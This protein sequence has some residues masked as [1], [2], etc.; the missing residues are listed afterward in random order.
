MLEIK[1]DTSRIDIKG[2]EKK[3]V[4]KARRRLNEYCRKE[5]V[6]KIKAVAPVGK[7]HRRKYKWGERTKF[8]KG[9]IKFRAFKKSLG[10][11]V[12]ADFPALFLD[13]GTVKRKGSGFITLTV[14]RNKR[15]IYECL[16]QFCDEQN[17]E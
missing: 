3:A 2:I 10:G 11:M 8:L 9:S 7:P 5:L 17:E 1:F 13:K 14:E 15:G 4:K 12:V 16:R 6:P